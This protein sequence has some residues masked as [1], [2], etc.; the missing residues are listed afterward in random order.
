[1][2]NYNFILRGVLIMKQEWKYVK[3]IDLNKILE[4]EKH[5]NYKFPNNFVNFV[6]QYNG[7]KPISKI[8]YVNKEIERVFKTMLSFNKEDRENIYIGFD[9]KYKNNLIAV[10]S[11]EVGNLICY[12]RDTNNIV[13]WNHELDELQFVAYKWIDFV[14]SLIYI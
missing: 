3:K 2:V 7:G 13:Y 11:D 9:T 14:N 4:V 8:F 5:F 1:M 12:E 6:L 10:A